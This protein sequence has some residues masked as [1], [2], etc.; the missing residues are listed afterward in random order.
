MKLAHFGTFDVENYGDLLFPLILERRLADLCEEFVHVSPAGSPPIYDDCV[1]TVGF[2]QL[3]RRAPDIDGAVVGGGQI[4]R[5]TPTPLEAYNRGGIS[6]FLTYPSLWLGAAYVAARANAPLCWNASGVPRDF[7]P[8]A[9]QLVRWAASV[10]DYIGVRDESSRRWL[11]EAGIEQTIEVV[12]DTAIEVSKLWTGDEISEAYENAFA[13]RNRSVPRSTLALHVNRR[14]AGEDI[15]AIAARLDRLCER[16][17]ASPILI[18]IGP[19]HGDSEVQRLVAREMKSDPLLI[20]KPG[21]LR[22]I[23][24]CI[25][26]SDAYLGSSL[27]GMVTACS[28]GRR[29]IL[30]ASA[31][32]PKYLGFL[33]H[34]TLSE[35]LA[36]SWEQAEMRL[37][38]LISSPPEVWE[39]VPEVAGPVLERH[40]SR[41]RELL[42]RRS[43]TQT[44]ALW[45][46]DKRYAS[47]QLQ[48]IV[49][50]RYGNTEPFHA[51]IAEGLE[52]SQADLGAV[53]QQL[54]N[55]S[56]EVQRLRQTNRELRQQLKR[57]NQELARLARWLDEVDSAVST[58]LRSRQWRTGRA[59][60][61]IYHRAQRRPGEGPPA[62]G[63]LKAALARFRAWREDEELSKSNDRMGGG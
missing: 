14:W 42:T 59:I 29:G 16:V 15:A 27:H 45:V 20:D 28:F 7:T 48:N 35:W 26:R 50:D 11:Q 51:I 49:V 32:D 46:D 53:R 55:E 31:K 57:Y 33:Q 5:A 19:C 6:P 12:P 30:V 8:V 56:L 41:V 37:D 44:S 1:R 2:E 25:A 54:A 36:E 23:A 40:W 39:Q 3:L 63:R 60:G 21:S 22:E 9:A 43:D 13:K 38:D 17:D 18:A 24:A 62:E 58:L 61:E 4:I 34:F 47:R 10:T 52:N